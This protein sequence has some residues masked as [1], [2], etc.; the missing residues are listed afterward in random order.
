MGGSQ[1]KPSASGMS[2]EERLRAEQEAL[3]LAADWADISQGLR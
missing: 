2:D 1:G 3:D